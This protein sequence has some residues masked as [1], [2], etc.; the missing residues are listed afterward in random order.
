MLF[1]SARALA[2]PRICIAAVSL[3][4]T[5]LLIFIVYR[6]EIFKP[7]S[8]PRHIY[9]YTAPP[10]ADDD[11]R[12]AQYEQY[13]RRLRVEAPTWL[14]TPLPLAYMSFENSVHYDISTSLGEYEWNYTTLPGIKHDG[15]FPLNRKDSDGKQLFT[16]S[17]FHQIRCLN[18]IREAIV[19]FRSSNPDNLAR[20]NHLTTHC[21]NYLR[22]MVLCRSDLTLESARDPVGPRTVVSDITH[23]CRDWSV[24]WKDLD[25]NPLY[26][27]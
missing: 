20:P 23:V 16:V 25:E 18:I 13:T 21:M 5:V 22:Q 4:S 7:T 27:G 26:G 9:S 8:G 12:L 24:V 17:M 15:S 11:L 1:L 3:L 14:S 6:E 10:G 2:S 19:R